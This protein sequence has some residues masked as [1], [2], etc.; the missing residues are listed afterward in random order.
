MKKI[1]TIITM[2]MLIFVMGINNVKA[3]GCALSE[4][5]F[6]LNLGLGIGN[7][8]GHNYDNHWHG[9]SYVVPTFNAAIDYAFLGNVINQHGSVS[10]GL[11]M[12]FGRG[13]KKDGGYKL[14]DGRWRIGTRGALHYTWVTN[15]DT[16]AGLSVGVRS[17]KYKLKDNNG[18]TSDPTTDSHFDCFGFAGA[19]YDFGGIAVYSELAFTNFAFF[20]IG[21][22]FMF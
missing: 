14:I 13:S 15:L 10:G 18:N 4:G 6:A 7:N 1:F 16:Y 8:D 12:G 11:Y 3:Q 2:A 22:A 20:Q 9:N 5:S 17:D 21:V 19:R